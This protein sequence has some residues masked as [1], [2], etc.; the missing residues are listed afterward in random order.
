MGAFHRPA[1]VL[2]A[3]DDP[4]DRT[5]ARDAMREC[6]P[7]FD[8]RFVVDGAELMAYLYQSGEF[9]DPDDAPRPDLILLDLNMPRKNGREALVEIKADFDLG[10]I[11]VVVLTTSRADEDAFASYK[12]GANSCLIKPMSF[13]GL[14]GAMDSLA[15]Y[16][17]ETAK[18]P[19]PEPGGRHGQRPD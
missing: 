2:M 12:L 9:A 11:P 1:I 8:F 10:T 5:L 14:V 3:D 19:P 16:W 17:F 7:S 18:L 13:E 15:S 6:R 4:E